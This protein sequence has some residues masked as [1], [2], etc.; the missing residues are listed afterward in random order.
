MKRTAFIVAVEMF[1]VFQTWGPP[2]RTFDGL[3]FKACLY[4]RYGRNIYV[5]RS[6]PGQTAAAAAVQMAVSEFRVSEIWNFGVAGGLVPELS[7]GDVCVADKI[8]HWD[9]DV[10]T[11]IIHADIPADTIKTATAASGDRVVAAK[12]QRMELAERTGA[13]LVEMEAAGIALTAKRNGLPCYFIKGI[14][15]GLETPENELT[16]SFK[17]AALKTF[18]AADMMLKNT[19]KKEYE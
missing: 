7:V 9:S 13:S 5:I 18:T 15:D 4:E 6:G 8:I 3:P 16:A 2:E 19:G 17:E 11:D 14:S 10:D 12:S 1:A